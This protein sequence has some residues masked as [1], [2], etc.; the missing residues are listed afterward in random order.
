M[1]PTY[2][3][4]LSYRNFTSVLCEG[5]AFST[6]SC[7]RKPVAGCADFQISSSS[8]PSIWGAFAIRT[9][10]TWGGLVSAIMTKQ[11]KKSRKDAK[12]NFISFSIKPKWPLIESCQIWWIYNSCW[13]ELTKFSTELFSGIV[14]GIQ[15]KQEHIFVKTLCTPF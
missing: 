13:E 3:A 4:L 9:A 5:S 7:W 12:V 11:K 8:F 6:G 2:R 14:E 10:S 1:A 15:T